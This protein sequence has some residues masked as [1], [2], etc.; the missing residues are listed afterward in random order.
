MYDS[1]LSL[2]AK[3]TVAAAYS[4]GDSGLAGGLIF[5]DKDD[6]AGG[7]RYMEAAPQSTEWT[8]RR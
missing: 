4:I 5:Y 6:W 3:R 7:W 8:Y 1:D 2:C